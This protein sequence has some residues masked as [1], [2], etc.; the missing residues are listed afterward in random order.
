MATNTTIDRELGSK[1]I[2]KRLKQMDK[3]FVTIGIHD[4]A[5]KYPSGVDILDVAFW[6]EFGTKTA[7]E[8]SFI[9]ATIDENKPMLLR[10]IKKQRDQVLNLEKTPEQVLD[11]IGFM[12][13]QL[14]QGKMETLREPANAPA[15]IAQKPETGDNPLIDSRLLKRSVNFETTIEG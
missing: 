13:Q 15:T 10:Q 2:Q 3:S 11:G 12:I 1:E 4:G 6:N 14:I 5:G 9:R 7:P 8:R